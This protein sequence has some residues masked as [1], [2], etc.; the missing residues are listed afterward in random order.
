MKN[1][2]FAIIVGAIIFFGVLVYMV[3]QQPIPDE[4]A[5]RMENT[6]PVNVDEGK[7]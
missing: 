7:G 4:P 3:W 2:N 5:M 1:L 6:L